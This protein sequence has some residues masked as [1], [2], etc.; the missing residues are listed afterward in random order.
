MNDMQHLVTIS[1][2]KVEVTISG[3]GVESERRSKLFFRGI[4]G[5][6][7][8][9]DTW[10]CPVRKPPAT[11]LVLRIHDWLAKKGFNVQCTGFA[12]EAID[13]ELARRRSFERTQLAAAEFVRNPNEFDYPALTR[14]LRGAGWLESRALRD[15]QLRG[16]AHALTAINCANFS[17]PGAGKTATALAVACAHLASQTIDCVFVVGPLACFRPWEEE[18]RLALGGTLRTS[19]V[20][21]SKAERKDQY[22][23]VGPGSLTVMSYAT[24]ASDQLYLTTLFR[25]FKVML[26][27]DESHRVKRFRG[28]L[29]A[30]ALVSLA[31]NAAVRMILSGTPMPQSGRDLFSQLNIL[32]PGELLTGSRDAFASKVKRS[33]SSVVEDVGPFMS[34]TSKAELGLPPYHVH[35]HEVQLKGTQAEIYRLIESRFRERIENAESW[36]EKIAALKRGRPIRLLQAAANPDLL[37]SSDQYYGIPVL[38][39]TNPTLM[40]RL[41]SFRHNEVP[42]KTKFAL[43]LIRDIAG[44]N[45]KVVCWSNFVP[46]LDHLSYLVRKSVGIPCFQIDGRVPASRDSMHTDS[47]VVA[48]EA[49]E[50]DT[51][52]RI[53][54]RFLSS[55]GPGVLVTNPASCSESISLHST[56]R[57]AIYLDRTFDCALFLQSIDRI[58][59]LGLPDDAVVNIHL[60]LS[61]TE[62]G[63]TIDGLVHESLTRKEEAMKALLESAELKPLA[64]SED[65]LDD[66]EGDGED[67]AVILRYLLGETDDASA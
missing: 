17:V 7:L 26:I 64:L 3:G 44:R 47:L 53:I 33:F 61:T 54:A 56:C 60:L 65:P 25:T 19:R 50:V 46:N 30:P 52:E 13:Q 58:H 55:D 39:A 37:N 35:T 15:H 31:Q 63:V 59:R 14:T 40:E 45:E 2:T 23:A 12:T 8:E 1:S 57:N 24:A 48:E 34:R 20:R 38:P 66:A 67:L 29:W 22:G 43:E 4:L 42:E 32:W 41:H 62:N 27:V 6:S 10:R 18:A 11:G 49:G 21:G 28:G 5:C 51:R 16:A 9:G 36:S